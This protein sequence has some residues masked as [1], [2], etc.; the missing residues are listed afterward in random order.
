MIHF[1]GLR[2]F[3]VLGIHTSPNSANQELNGLDE[4]YEA[5]ASFWNT[6]VCRANFSELK[7]EPVFELSSLFLWRCLKV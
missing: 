7:F 5:A 1:A 2:K 3:G 6:Q 4:V